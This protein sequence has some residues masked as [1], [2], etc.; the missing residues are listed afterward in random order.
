MEQLVIFIWF[1]HLLNHCQNNLQET[2]NSLLCCSQ[3]ELWKVDKLFVYAFKEKV[4]K[5]KKKLSY[6]AI[7]KKKTKK[8]IWVGPVTRKAQQECAVSLP[9][10][11]GD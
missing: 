8:Y 9:N 4:R 10:S 3:H 7:N 1:Q 2:C 5:K 11:C 6:K